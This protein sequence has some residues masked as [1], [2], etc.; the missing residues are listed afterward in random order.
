M[1]LSRVSVRFGDITDSEELFDDIRDADF[2]NDEG[3][4]I[5]VGALWVGRNY[6][7]G[8]Q[9]TNINEPEFTFPDVN[10]APYT[11]PLSIQRLQSDK[12]YRKDRQLKL[13]GSI[14]SPERRFSAHLGV[15]VDPA[16]D[17]LGDRFQ[18]ATL[19]AGF[20]TDSRWVPS[21]RIG[22]RKNLTG[23]ELGYASFGLTAFKIFNFD[24]ASALDTVSIDGE[25]L[26]QGL[27]ASLGFQVSW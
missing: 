5:D 2:N 20:Q 13:E 25:K 12:F 22:V 27:M 26:P 19:S 8:A 1:K 24:I 15:D 23:T 17:P 11:D 18:W 21:V 9:I 16:T 6:Q 10:L 3:L 7:L 4:G 14:F